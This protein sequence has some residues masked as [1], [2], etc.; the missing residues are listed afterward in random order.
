MRLEYDLS[1]SCRSTRLNSSASQ[2]HRPAT[3]CS[4]PGWHKVHAPTVSRALASAP[5]R[6]TSGARSLMRDARWRDPA[7][8]ETLNTSEAWRVKQQLIARTCL[9]VLCLLGSA[10][11]GEGAD[12]LVAARALWTKMAPESYSYVVHEHTTMVTMCIGPNSRAFSRNPLRIHVRNGS[13]TKVESVRDGRL[14]A[15]C[16]KTLTLYT[17][18]W[19]FEYIERVQGQPG[20]CGALPLIEVEYDATFGF[21]SSVEE[22]CVLDGS[23]YTVRDFRV[24]K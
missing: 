2:L 16:I 19:L 14:P 10:H 5:M 13:I 4:D 12:S 11:A 20:E 3:A 22:N 6:H 23:S 9:L 17:I 24:V 21:P 8:R 7:L 15:S 1:L 18:D